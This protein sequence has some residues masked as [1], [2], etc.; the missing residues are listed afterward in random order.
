MAPE[1]VQDNL[2]NV[3]R[4]NFPRPIPHRF[5]AA[6]ACEGE[7]RRI[8]G[9]PSRESIFAC[10]TADIDDESS[11]APFHFRDRKV[12]SVENTIQVRGNGVAPLQGSHFLYGLEK[13]D[14]GVV[15]QDVDSP[16]LFDAKAD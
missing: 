9:S 4:R 15:D 7:F 13:T 5:A 2:R 16:Q 6:K 12:T 8:V 3:T 10:Q 14:S 11:L 1:S